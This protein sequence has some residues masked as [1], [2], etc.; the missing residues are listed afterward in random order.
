MQ[1][2]TS[3]TLTRSWETLSLTTSSERFLLSCDFLKPGLWS[4]AQ[5]DAVG[6][7]DFHT[8]FFTVFGTNRLR[9]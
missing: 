3:A 5:L 1:L 9:F 7:K 2:Y 4:L 8:H 6:R